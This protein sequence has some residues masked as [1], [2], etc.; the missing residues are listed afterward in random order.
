[1][2]VNYT[3]IGMLIGGLGLFLL[4]VSMITDGLKLAAGN[5]LRDI[6][7]RSTRTPAKGILTG[8]GITAI[9]QSSSAVT[10]ATIGFVNA[11]LLSLY[12]ALGVVYGAN[13][14]TTMT[15]W[16]V[17][18]IGFKIKVEAFALPMIGIG[19]MLRLL[20]GGSRWGSVGTSLAGF[21]LFFVGIDVLKSAFEGMAGGID[22]QQQSVLG[23]T[24]V[25]VYLAIGFL[26][27]LFTQSSSAAIAIILTAA[28]G[29]VLTLEAAAAMVIGANVGTTSTAGFAVIGATPNAK[30]VASAHV[31]FN[32]LTGL[33]ALIILPVLFMVIKYAG[34]FLGMEDNPAVTLALFHTI[35]NILGVALMWPLSGKLCHFLLKR[36]RS[37]EEIESKPHYIDNTILVS[38]PLALNA[39]Y[40][41]LEHVAHVAQDMASMAMLRKDSTD[42]LIENK[43]VA[44]EN[45]GKLINTFTVDI[46]QSALSEETSQQLPKVLYALQCYTTIA[47]LAFNYA[48]HEINIKPLADSKLTALINEYKQ[49]AEEII[50]IGRQKNPALLDE[51]QPDYH[52]LY[53][54]LRSELLLA[55]TQRRLDIEMIGLLIDQI[56]RLDRIAKQMAKGTRLLTELSAITRVSSEPEDLPVEA[57]E[58]SETV[59]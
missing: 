14:G 29:G 57:D 21:G 52:N 39:L 20:K 44:V 38:P 19:M 17:A 30:R 48:R 25:L 7:A 31:V 27:T 3:I 8:I 1:M 42:K 40:L 37:T 12:Q 56:Y 41:E 26:M 59:Y 55:V 11:G 9:V 47:E 51:K 33:I 18:I 45:L 49:S 58:L 46:G 2:T 43:F 36:F 22:L 32:L 5:A 16:L 35:F 54:R 6:L 34:Q 13:I 50:E 15:G 4:A 23:V 10:V 53:R 28:T 24:G